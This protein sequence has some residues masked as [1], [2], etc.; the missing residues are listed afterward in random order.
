MRH[1]IFI[2]LF[3]VLIT[4]CVSHK[5]VTYFNDIAQSKSGTIALSG[6]PDVIFEPDDIVEIDIT[7]ASLETNAYFEKSG[8]DTDKK[9]SGNTY[10]VARDSTIDLP[11]I[12]KIKIAGLRPE[13][14]AERVRQSLLDYLQQPSVNIRLVSF[15]ITILGEV[16]EPG[17]YDIPDSR[18]N[19]LEAIGYAGDLTIYGRRDNILLIRTTADGKSYQRLNLNDSE[20]INSETFYLRNGD[21]LYIEPS[22]GATS[23]DDNAYRILPLVLSTL[24]FAV[25][26]IGL[27]R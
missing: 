12:G 6:P 4:S 8:S 20:F 11:L 21:V 23:K 27:T 7:S 18:V 17:V 13:A 1:P 2:V 25:V 9:Y 10:Q 26:V 19:L 16:E 5:K 3:A 22:K 24:T 15:S 14:A